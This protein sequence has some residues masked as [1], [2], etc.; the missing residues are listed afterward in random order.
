MARVFPERPGLCPSVNQLESKSMVQSTLP[1][2]DIGQRAFLMQLVRFVISGG[3]STA[4]GVGI[5]GLVALVLRWHP[6]LGNFLAYIVAGGISY[7]MHSRWSF[8]GHGRRTHATKVRFVMMSVASLTLNSFWVWLLTEGFRLSPAW[9]IV[10]MLFV[11]S[12]VTFTLN[13]HWVFR[14]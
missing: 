1:S 14:K 2:P 6:Q 9:P 8:R 5:Y 7:L 11:I 4:L 12:A 10:P 3:V 13:R